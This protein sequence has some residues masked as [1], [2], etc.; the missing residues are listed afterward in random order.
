MQRKYVH[1]KYVCLGL[2]NR[3]CHTL[4]A[5]FCLQILILGSNAALIIGT[6]QSPF[7]HNVQITLTGRRTDVPLALNNQL[8]VGSKAIGAFGNVS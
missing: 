3:S 4:L 8:I 6:Q 7:L 5:C 1:C 2:G